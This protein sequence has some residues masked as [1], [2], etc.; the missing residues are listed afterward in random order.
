[1]SQPK[2]PTVRELARLI[3]E[4]RKLQKSFFAGQKHLLDDT[5]RSE[6][7]LDQLVHAILSGQDTFD[8]GGDD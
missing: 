1:M 3:H 2:L 7:R 5:K 6:R 8:F 4:T